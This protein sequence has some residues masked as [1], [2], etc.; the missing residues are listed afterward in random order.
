ML[1]VTTFIG[2]YPYLGIF[3]LLILGGVGLPFPEDTTL[4]L[5]GFLIAHHVIKPLPTFL[6]I[7]P[8]LIITD[9]FL[10]LI[11]KK[12]GTM[13]VE[14]KWFRKVVSSGRLSQIEEKF[15]KWGI[16]VVLVGR[17]ALGLR[18]QVFVATGVMKISAVKFIIADAISALFTIALWGGIGYLGGNSIQVLKKDVTR[19]EH[20]AIVVS[21]LLLMSWIVFRYFRNSR[22]FEKK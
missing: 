3:L 19:I 15:K 13:V 9:C 5:S 1:E 10:Y 20:I 17:H 16:W 14:H 11:G 4:L 12:Y 22:K 2:Q 6:V 7:Y 18:A 21:I 8:S